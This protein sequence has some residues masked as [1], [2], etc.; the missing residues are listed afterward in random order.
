MLDPGSSRRSAFTIRFGL[1]FRGT[2]ARLHE[3]RDV[4][5]TIIERTLAPPFGTRLVGGVKIKDDDPLEFYKSEDVDHP[6]V[7]DFEAWLV[8]PLHI[9]D[10]PEEG[11]L[12]VCR[13]WVDLANLSKELFEGA[14]CMWRSCMRKG[15]PGTTTGT[16]GRG[17]ACCFTYEGEGRR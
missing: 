4:Q 17:W 2:P 16:V 6:S 14:T 11:I 8:V 9:M 13:V 12:K 7:H 15:R 3:L 5:E 10:V 1:G